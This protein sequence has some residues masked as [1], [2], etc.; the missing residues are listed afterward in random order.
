MAQDKYLTF[1]GDIRAIAPA[2]AAMLFVTAHP[3]GHVAALCRLDVEKQTLDETPLPA[4]GNDVVTDGQTVWV[5]GTDR[6][7]Y[8]VSATPGGKLAPLPAELDASPTKLALL[9]DG[10]LAAIAGQRL[11]ILAAKDGVLSQSL[12]LPEPATALATDP[13]GRWIVVGTAKGT[14][15]VFSAEEREKFLLSESSKL[16]EGAVTA[17]LFELDDLRFLSAG[18]DGKLLSTH[19]RGKLEPEDKGRGNNHSDTV[20]SLAWL[21][22]DRFVSGGLDSTIK[23]WPRVGAI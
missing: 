16:H 6:R 13:S 8:R 1:R 15:L 22:R 11:L 18:A 23:S 20:T 19:A 3:E 4:G 12:D 21:S 14:V 5:A 9:A 2:G 7:I 10:R 17:L